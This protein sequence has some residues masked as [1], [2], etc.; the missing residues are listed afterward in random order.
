MVSALSAVSVISECLYIDGVN[1]FH[2]GQLEDSINRNRVQEN[3]QQVIHKLDRKQPHVSDI[4]SAT[5]ILGEV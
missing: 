3:L 2:I 1:W 5:K 4:D